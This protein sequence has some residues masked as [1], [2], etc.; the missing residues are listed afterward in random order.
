MKERLLRVGALT[1]EGPGRL[2][3]EPDAA[4]VIDG[5][6]RIAA[7]GPYRRV[8]G[9][10]R[11]DRD[12]RGL[13]AIPGLIDAHCHLPQYPAVAAGGLELLPWLKRRIFPLE[14]GFR[15]PAV[16]GRARRFFA[17]MAAHGTT[18]ACVY[19]AIWKDS[20]ETCFEEA[21]ASGL[22]VIMGK[23]MMDRGSYDPARPPGRSRTEL[24]LAQSE[25]LC[26]R[27]HGRQGGRILYA[28]TPRFALSCSM[29]LMRGAAE[30]A[31]RY[32]AYLQTHL[33]ESPGEV[34]A[35][36]A[37]FRGARSYAEVYDKAGLLGP[38]TVLAHSIWLAP[39]ERAL[40]AKRGAVVA[41]CPTSNAFLASGVM[42]AGALARAGVPLALGSDVAAGPSL[43]LF[44]VMRQALYGQRLAAAHR[45]FTGADRFRPEDAFGMATLGGA[46]ALG[47]GDRIGS[48]EAGK[49][50]DLA[51]LDPAAYDVG[52]PPARSAAEALSRLVYRAER[53]AVREVYAAGRRIY[54]Q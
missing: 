4:L 3:H 39:A 54:P 1:L 51:V 42:D 13:L 46:R 35:V 23:V 9:A 48:L 27:W 40:I 22:R 36:R 14:R 17:D 5:R 31:A 24:S 7:V 25:E 21:A 18:T 28:F 30:L 34:A 8:A 52:F 10:R 53:A 47:L 44:G 43:C 33:S 12:L 32:G 2:R 26:R 16:R 29:A 11:P 15:G 37:A 6:G 19:A 50:A 20:A 41:H 49:D 38:R 45:L